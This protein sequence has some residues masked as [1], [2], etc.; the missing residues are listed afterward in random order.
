[1]EKENMTDYQFR[2]FLKMVL[3]IVKNSKD[4]KEATEKLVAEHGVRPGL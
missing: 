1:M 3:D 2:T 4:I